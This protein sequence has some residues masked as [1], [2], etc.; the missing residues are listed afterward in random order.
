MIAHRHDELQIVVDQQQAQPACKWQAL[1]AAC[2]VFRLFGVHAGGRFVQQQKARLGSQGA[3]DLEPAPCA[4]GEAVGAFLSSAFEAHEGELALRR[5]QGV[6]E[7]SSS[8]QRGHGDI[9]AR[10][11]AGE[12]PDVLKGSR[13][14]GPGDGVGRQ[15]ADVQGRR[16]IPCPR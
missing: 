12:E 8:R 15:R 5:G 14:A 3:G 4:V 6:A 10:A 11:E 2:K 13:Y 1:Q 7:T 9:L 16:S